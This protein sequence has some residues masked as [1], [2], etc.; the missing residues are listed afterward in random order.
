MQ[1]VHGVQFAAGTFTNLTQD[2]LDFHG[3]ME[4]Y[5]RAKKIL[6]DTLSEGAYAVSNL[7]DPHGRPIVSS[8]AARSIFYGTTASADVLGRAVSTGIDGTKIIIRY[9]E[10]EQR[11]TS[12]LIGRFNVSNILAAYATCLCFGID[13][14]DIARGIELLPGVRGRVERVRSPQGWTAIVDY[15]HTPDAL[16]NCL[17]SVRDL[18]GASA[19]KVITI[20]GCGGNRDRG[21]RGM[22]GRIASGLSDVTVITSDNP[23]NEEPGAIIR[24]VLQDVIPGKEVHVEVDRRKAISYGLGLARMGDVVV[25][26]GKGHETYQII[27]EA[28]HHFDDREEVEKFIATG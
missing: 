23:R 8:T 4:E 28:K 1:R 12:P 15:A 18:L 22:M 5:F 21:K 13:G 11:V 19:G 6:F 10:K 16:E 24:D 20:F 2:H 7:N 9:N 3:S 26:A 27:G 14:V 17:K 25:I